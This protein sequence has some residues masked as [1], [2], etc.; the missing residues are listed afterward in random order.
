VVAPSSIASL[1]GTDLPS[2][3]LT[4]GGVAAKVF[5]SSAR[6]I[7]YL[8]PGTLAAGDAAVRVGT[9][10]F[11]PV[12]VARVA[13]G[14]HAMP[15]GVAAATAIRRVIATNISSTVDVFRC[16]ASGTDCTA[17]PI[18]VGV[19]A[20]VFLSLYAT[21]LRNAS[22]VSVTIGGE[23][24]PVQFS[25]PQGTYE[26]LDQIN[27]QLPLSLRGTGSAEIVAVADGVSSNSVKISIQ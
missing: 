26:G 3:E 2:G 27:V 20:P 24:V 15:G 6:Q 9:R 14:L 13:P 22:Q 25:G 8:V 18:D 17:V 12:Q 7:N 16:N 5:F 10:D 11:G 23:S 1:Y 4:V 21:G 19:D